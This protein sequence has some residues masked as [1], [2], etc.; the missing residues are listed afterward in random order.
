MNIA[1]SAIIVFVLLLPPVAFYISFSYG[2][3]QKGKPQ[4]SSLEV[5]MA[6]TI[7]A[8]IAH[9]TGILLFYQTVR[10]DLVILLL[11]GKIESVVEKCS[12]EDLR[13][14]LI[15]F[16]LYNFTQL[17]VAVIVGRLLRRY[18][19]RI[20]IHSAMEALRIYNHWW[21]LFNAFRSGNLLEKKIQKA[22]DLVFVDVL[23]NT[24]SGTMLYSGYLTDFICS[25]ETLERLYL[26]ESSK[27]DFK[28]VKTSTHGN[29][30]LNKPGPPQ[31]VKGEILAIP[32]AEILNINV[33][34]VDLTVYTQKIKNPVFRPMHVW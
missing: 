19:Q 21:Y 20:K 3:F 9:T 30:I 22:F 6:C 8:L 1:F 16:S 33:K 11:S 23:V 34:F 14:Y 24:N 7:F 26:S 4:W 15:D 12:N 31:P 10:L 29:A 32:A 25:G 18:L 13:R 28:T 2:R 17:I 5:M 27:R